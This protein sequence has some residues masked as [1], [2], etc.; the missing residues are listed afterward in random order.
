MKC[1]LHYYMLNLETP[2]YLE[3]SLFAF[4]DRKKG[5]LIFNFF[6]EA[7]GALKLV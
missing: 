3:A 6:S 5:K 4:F 1:K 2:L 7:R